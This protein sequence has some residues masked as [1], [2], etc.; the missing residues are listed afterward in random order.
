MIKVDII[1]TFIDPPHYATAGSSGVDLE[2]LIA[3]WIPPGT[4][5][6][7]KTG[8]YVAVPEGWELQIRPR[9]GLAL[10]HNV[11]VLNTPGTIDSDYRGEIG[12]ILMNH[13]KYKY[14]EVKAGDRI[15]QAVLC[16]IGKIQWNVVTELPETSRI[17]GFGSTGMT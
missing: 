8:L 4:S 12:V 14:F 15:A 2:A 5:K 13:D 11:T 3:D 7:I 17:G 10:K 9:S 16:P 6:L 1:T